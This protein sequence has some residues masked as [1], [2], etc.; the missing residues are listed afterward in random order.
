M[1]NRIEKAD[2]YRKIQH[3]KIHHQHSSE[4][5]KNLQP[6]FTQHG[7][8][9]RYS[10]QDVSKVK[11]Q[12]LLQLNGNINNME[13]KNL[14]DCYQNL[15]NVLLKSVKDKER[16]SLLIVGPR[17]SG[18]TS[19]MKKVLL[20]LNQSFGDEFLAIQLSASAHTDDNAA[21]REIAKQLDSKLSAEPGNPIIESKS[22]NETFTNILR[23]LNNDRHQE[24]VDKNWMPLIFVIDEFEKFTSDNKQTLLYNLLDMSQSSTVP[25]TIVGLTTKINAKDYLEKRVSSRFSQRVLTIEPFTDFT[26]F[27]QNYISNLKLDDNFIKNLESQ[28]Y[29]VAWNLSLLDE[30]TCLRRYSFNNFNSIRNFREINNYCKI[31]VSKLTQDD[32][33]L[34]NTNLTICMNHNRSGFVQSAINSLSESELILVISAARWLTKFEGETVNF[35]LAHSEYKTC[36]KKLNENTNTI[37][38]FNNVKIKQRELSKKILRTSWESLHQLNIIIGPIVSYTGEDVDKRSSNNTVLEEN[39]M[40]LLNVTLDELLVLIDDDNKFKTFVRI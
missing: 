19:I 14:K 34:P 2:K 23:V 32:P 1:T 12:V 13:S 38:S 18:K 24:E 20:E 40:V 16:H 37:S 33:F 35:N 6:V 15:Y 11:N 29:G 30:N 5:S 27:F 28:E 3:I 9:H 22:I 31:L 8:D 17:A 25:V 21:L 26:K 39:S 10:L 4:F 7:K 36:F